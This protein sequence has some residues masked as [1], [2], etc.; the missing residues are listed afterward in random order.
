MS[1]ICARLSVSPG[2]IPGKPGVQERDRLVQQR[3]QRPTPSDIG[4]EHH[5]QIQLP[6]IELAA[7]VTGEHLDQMQLDIGIP[8]AH[9]F[10]QRQRQ[11]ACSPRWQSNTDVAAHAS[12]LRCLHRC[13]GL[14]QGQL[15]VMQKG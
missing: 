5:R 11:D 15:S 2:G 4:L 14:A 6:R 12:S 10:D 9:R 8:C 7:E 1:P 13:V 3:N